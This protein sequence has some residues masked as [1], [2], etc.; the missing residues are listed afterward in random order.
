MGDS[1]LR[2]CPV[3]RL[4]LRRG[5]IAQYAGSG[6]LASE[7]LDVCQCLTDGCLCARTV[8]RL[9]LRLSDEG[10]RRGSDPIMG[11]R[12]GERQ[13]LRCVARLDL[14]P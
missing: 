11:E 3:S 4:G 5:N 2:A 7:R 9:G 1:G 12:L 14:W 10:Q 8:S 6:C 13:R